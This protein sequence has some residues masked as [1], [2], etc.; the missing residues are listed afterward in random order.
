M[1]TKNA[2]VIISFV[3]LSSYISGKMRSGIAA[4]R[5]ACEVVCNQPA[6]VHA[7][8]A[9]VSAS[10]GDNITRARVTVKLL[11]RQLA[12]SMLHTCVC[13]VTVTSFPTIL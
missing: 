1:N 9:E 3:S 8:T 13:F 6:N 7:H 2:F 11:L 12:S 10:V 4:M 5:I